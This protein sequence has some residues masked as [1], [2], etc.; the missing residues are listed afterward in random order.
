[1]IWRLAG[2]PETRMHAGFQDVESGAWYAQAVDWAAENGVVT[3]YSDKVF[4]P[5]DSVTREQLAV[6]LNRWAGSASADE[7]AL[8]KIV[9]AMFGTIDPSAF[10]GEKINVP[11]DDAASVSEWAVRGV[12][13][14]YEAGVLNG[15]TEKRLAPQEKAARVEVAAMLLR[16]TAIIGE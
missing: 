8:A 1:M 12:N 10:Y 5:N 3:G 9:L 7:N 13:W 2:E 11:F 14:A 16:T 4:A 15:R 6:I